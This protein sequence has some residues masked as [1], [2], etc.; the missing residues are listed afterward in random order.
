VKTEEEI[1]AEFKT[2]EVEALWDRYRA[3]AHAMQSGVEFYQDKTDQT[4]KHLRVGVNM[5]LVDSSALAMV[6]M[7]KGLLTPA[8][9]IESL[10]S[11]LEQEVAQYEAKI[12][13]Q[14]GTGAKIKL[15]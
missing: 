1:A 11:K 13:A 4:P 14:H 6:L 15:A 12:N 10:I 8:E 2:P 5:A 3:L 7:R 9:L